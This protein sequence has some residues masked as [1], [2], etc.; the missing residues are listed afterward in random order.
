MTPIETICFFLLLVVGILTLCLVDANSRTIARSLDSIEEEVYL[1]V[2][3][4]YRIDHEEKSSFIIKRNGVE[5][6]VIQR[7]AKRED[8]KNEDQL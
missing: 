3:T 7:T 8:T 2:N 1:L 4:I 5:F 6:E